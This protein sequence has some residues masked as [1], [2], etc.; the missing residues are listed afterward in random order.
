MSLTPF[1]AQQPAQPP[2]VARPPRL[3]CSPSERS[4]D[5]KFLH[6]PSGSQSTPENGVR[7]FI[8]PP[9]GEI[10]EPDPFFGATARTTSA[11]RPPSKV[12]LLAIRAQLG[13]QVSTFSVR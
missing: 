11:R 3:G 10:N 12:G 13:P 5:L 8:S 6:F 1:S 4:S 2:L 9:F 7:V